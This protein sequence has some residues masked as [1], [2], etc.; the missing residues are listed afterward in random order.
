M[1]AALLSRVGSDA[2]ETVSLLREL[3]TRQVAIEAKLDIL[4][5]LAPGPRDQGDV[6]LVGI[7]ATV[8]RGLPFTA[9]ALWRR[10][11]AGDA[12]LAEAFATCDIENP[13]QL[14]KLLRRLEGRDVDGIR[15]CRVGTNREGIVWHARVQE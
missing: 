6:A 8:A 4:L 11:V 14:G 3:I 9:A 2:I 10:R 5:R 7:I 15:L 13:K 12:A 1:R